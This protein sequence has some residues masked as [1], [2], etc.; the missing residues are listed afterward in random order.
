M[1]AM[2]KNKLNTD[3]LFDF[4][5]FGLICTDK[6]HKLA[7]LINQALS[8]RLIKQNDLEIDFVENRKLVIANFFSETENTSIRLLKNKSI[9]SKGSDMI[10]LLPELANFDYFIL[11]HGYDEEYPN[12][13][14][15]ISLQPVRQISFM[16]RL[17]INMIKSKHNLLF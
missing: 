17:D 2:K 7:W 13:F 3:I 8:I 16:Q 11:A 9:L 4:E 15:K 6:E 14:F 10:Y 1:P 5:L 12:D